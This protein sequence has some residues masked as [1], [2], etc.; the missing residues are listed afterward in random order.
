MYKLSFNSKLGMKSPPRKAFGNSFSLECPERMAAVLIFSLFLFVLGCS[1]DMNKKKASSSPEPSSPVLVSA[2]GEVLLLRAGGI[3]W[4]EAKAGELLHDG[5]LIRTNA[6]GN[7]DI[8]YP[9]GMVVRVREET[10]VVVQHALSDEIEVVMPTEIMTAGFQHSA[11]SG[12]DGVWDE[13]DDVS[14]ATPSG[15]PGLEKS[16]PF[17]QVQRITQFGRILQLV[18][19]VEAGSRLVINNEMVEV[20]GDGSF[21]HFTNPF[22]GSSAEAHLVMKSTDLAG[23]TS[24]LEATYQFGPYVGD[25]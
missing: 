6:P 24:S 18:G 17:I 8:R 1:T 7:A 23:R 16:R 4:R 11:F 12:F 10:I 15:D 19:A 14:D 13:K 9:G 25:N 21:L 20:G 5:D 22:P 3:E 2:T